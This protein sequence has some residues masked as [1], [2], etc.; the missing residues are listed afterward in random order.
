M[1][2]PQALTQLE[3]DLR[4]FDLY[5]EYCHGGID[6]R[7]FLARSAAVTVGGLAMAQALLP[8][9]AAAQTISF[10]DARIK[11][12]YVS[13]P[14]PGGNGE[15]MRGYLV[16]PAGQGSFPAVLVIHENRGLNPYIEDVARRLAV[17]GFLAL[18]PDG[19]SSLGG[20]P[21]N[22][23]DGRAM[24]AKLDQQKLRTDM[25][26]GA[27]FVKA[28]ALSSGRLAVT[29][30]CWGGG[31][32]NW[33]ATVMGA[34]MQ[35]GAPYYGAAAETASVPKIKAPLLIHYADKDERINAMRPAFE[36]AL[37]DAGV[38]FEA[39][40]YAG[41]QHGFHNDSTPRHDEAAAKLSWERTLGFFR[42]RLT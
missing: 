8:D 3:I 28:H 7:T 27:R 38:P 11:A 18:A 6:R 9:Y 32:T 37:Q 12:R 10:T 16:Q 4:V 15:N 1:N 21:G 2:A 29:G 33:L 19:L 13:Y 31:T 26:N 5:D 24:Q 17:E 35:A 22:D 41:T 23:D 20:Y 14:S 36:A 25:L 39:H 40:V 34:D 30:F 42:Q